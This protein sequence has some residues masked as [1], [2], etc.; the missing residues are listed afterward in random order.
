VSSRS[1]IAFCCLSVQQTWH[2]TWIAR[3]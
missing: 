3:A 2:W 1:L